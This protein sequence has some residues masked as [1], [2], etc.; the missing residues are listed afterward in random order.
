MKRRRS[1]SGLRIYSGLTRSRIG[2]S[3]MNLDVSIYE[4]NRYL[5]TL[6]SGEMQPFKLPLEPGAHDLT[7]VFSWKHDELKTISKQVE[8]PEGVWLST[9][10]RSEEGRGLK[11][12]RP[13]AEI[14]ITEDR[15]PVLQRFLL[16][17]WW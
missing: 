14:R 4:N 2:F 10:C 12:R 8:I 3:A 11:R 7:F 16:D 13:L 5:A 6:L 17:R 1:Q 9:Y 15:P